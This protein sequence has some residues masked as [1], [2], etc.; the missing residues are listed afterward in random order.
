MNSIF[1]K[2]VT[3]LLLIIGSPSLVIGVILG[4][5]NDTGS[6]EQSDKVFKIICISFLMIIIGIF[7]ILK[8]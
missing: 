8:K 7:L 2:I 3:I 5:F 4:M 6:K 1:L